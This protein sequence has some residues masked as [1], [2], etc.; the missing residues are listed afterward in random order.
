MEKIKLKRIVLIILIILNCITIFNFSAQKADKSSSTSGKIVDV[1]MKKVYKNNVT[2]E[3]EPTIRERVTKLV[4]KGAHFSIYTCLGILT[5]T[6]FGTYQVSKGKRFAY[7]ICFCFLYACSD[8]LHQRFVEGRSCEFGD[9]CIDTSGAT[10]GTLLVMLAV[11]I[12]NLLK[13]DMK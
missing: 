11:K 12:K 4:R 2:K 8:E 1:V 9:V 6:Y 7:A 5:Y 10:F 13:N 3:K